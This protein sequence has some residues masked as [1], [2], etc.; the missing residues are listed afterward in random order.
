MMMI[1]EPNT[2]AAAWTDY[3]MSMGMKAYVDT[4]FNKMADHTI[5]FFCSHF[6]EYSHCCSNC[7]LFKIICTIHCS[8][9]RDI[10]LQSTSEAGTNKEYEYMW[11]E[12]RQK[13]W[14]GLCKRLTMPSE[15]PMSITW[16]NW[17]QVI[18]WPR[19]LLL[20]NHWLVI[21]N[22]CPGNCFIVCALVGLPRE[23]EA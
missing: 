1:Q 21:L 15:S 11:E 13:N 3:A 5:L 8:Q 10:P 16:C 2:T 4:T 12:W 7:S 6:Y 23:S 18:V 22:P 19:L 20:R 9:C 17:C 14:Q